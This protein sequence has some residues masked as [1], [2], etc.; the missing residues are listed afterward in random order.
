MGAGNDTLIVNG[1]VIN[2]TINLGG[3]NNQIFLE[4]P[5]EGTSTIEGSGTNQITVSNLVG[6][7]I[8]GGSGDDTL[9]LTR[10]DEFGSFD[11]TAGN[12][13][14]NG[15][16]GIYSSRDVITINGGD[17]GF[18]NAIRLNNVG[19]I[20]TG[21][22]ND[23]VIMNLGAS[24]TGQLLGGSGLDRLEFHNWSLPVAVDLDRGSAT[25]INNGRAGALAGFEQVKGSN[26][27]DV[28][29]SSGAFNGIDG[30]LGDDVMYL[31]WSPWLSAPGDGLQVVG[32]GGNDLFVF[33]D[34]DSTTP[35]NWDGKSGLPTLQDL[36]FSYDNK[37]GIGLTDRIGVV[38]NV[39]NADGTQ[40]QVFQE[41]LPTNGTGI[42]NA[43]L[44]PIA[45]LEQLLSGMSD[46]T[47][48]LAISY[49]PLST[50]AAELILLG[51]NGKGTFGNIAH[52]AGTRFD[53]TTLS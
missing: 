30:G 19:N 9:T 39:I 48:Q 52:L 46:N 23:V 29:I 31:R 26:G 15:P 22:N 42:G 34:L 49:D 33:S 28:L 36:D 14:I 11:G 1:R 18:Y 20:D 47:K 21:S 38:Q 5:L 45:P 44:L 40:N 10:A 4:T 16:S 41:L 13:A 25:A 51:S 12:N 35:L 7:A 24:L 53:G 37:G 6:S 27:D 17:Q 32:G 3:G 50:K 43:K 2:S 8:V